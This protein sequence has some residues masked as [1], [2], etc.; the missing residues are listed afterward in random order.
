MGG[1][2]PPIGGGHM[3][4]Q[5]FDGGGGIDA[6]FTTDKICRCLKKKQKKNNNNN[7]N[8]NN[9]NS[10]NENNNNNNFKKI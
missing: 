2:V 10:N 9:N 3:G 5:G 8:N 1:P 4:G 7:S 6:W